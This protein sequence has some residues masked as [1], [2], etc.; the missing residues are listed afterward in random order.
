MECE[1]CTNLI[2]DLSNINQTIV[3]NWLNKTC[4]ADFLS[5]K[6]C[7]LLTSKFDYFYPLLMSLLKNEE[8]CQLLGFCSRYVILKSFRICSM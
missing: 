4:D 3:S 2:G 1:M 8:L 5:N 7:Y 6:T